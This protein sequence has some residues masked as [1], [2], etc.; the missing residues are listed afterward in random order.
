MAVALNGCGGGGAGGSG[1]G[2]GNAAAPTHTVGGTVAGLG[3]AS[4][5]TLANGADSLPVPAGAT[6]FSMQTAVPEGTNYAVTVRNSPAGLQCSVSQG[7]GTMAVSHVTNI[8]V[9]CSEAYSVGGNV[10]GLTTS[11]LV[12]ASSTE[13]LS[14]AAGA[15]TFMMP[16]RLPPGAAYDLV[17]KTQPADMNCEVK[18]GK[19]AVGTRDVS[20]ITVVCNPSAR[21]LGG[22]SPGDL[23]SSGEVSVSLDCG[24]GVCGVDSQSYRYS[25]QNSTIRVRAGGNWLSITI[26]GSTPWPWSGVMRAPSDESRF[27]PGTYAEMWQLDAPSIWGTFNWSGEN[28]GFEGGTTSVTINSVTYEGDVLAG[29]D[30]N[31]DHSVH[32]FSD[33]RGHVVWTKAGSTVTI[34]PLTPPPGELWR[35]AAGKVPV[36]GNYIYLE[37]DAADFVGQGL[38][39]TQTPL[40]SLL[41]VETTSDGVLVAAEGAHLV[42]GRIQAMFGQGQL[43]NGYYQRVDRFQIGNP[44][45][46]GLTWAV[47]SRACNRSLGWFIVDGIAYTNGVVTA[48]DLR[49]EQHCELSRQALHGQVRWRASDTT[50]AAG[51]TTPPAGLWQPAPGSTPT[52]GNYVYLASDAGDFIGAGVAGPAMEYLYRSP[53][54]DISVNMNGP[55]VGP[56]LTVNIGPFGTW[57]GVF[58]GMYSLTRFKPGY[59][60]PLLTTYDPAFGGVD[61]SGMHKRCGFITGWLVFDSVTYV[62]DTLTSFDLRFEQHCQGDKAALHGKIHWSSP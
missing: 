7:A 25:P 52:S 6:A 54:N 15:S 39:Y 28:V 26:D 38:T 37:S 41:T 58:S 61:W 33:L 43:Q 12:L 40:N 19:G 3:S 20:G 35:P 34:V 53:G 49:F 32:G 55:G 44:A 23:P 21:S 27:K 8:A 29:I 62:G 1:P 46:G 42:S 48:L 31:F 47:D 9:T 17:V 22:P 59:Y 30:F 16:T 60:G 57:T 14:V 13:T 4:G 56:N 5:L 36:T 24:A 11:G 45:R 50:A 10:A 2:G 18:E 51:P